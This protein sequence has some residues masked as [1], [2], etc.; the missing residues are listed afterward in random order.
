MS[1]KFDST[2]IRDYNGRLT[3]VSP[4]TGDHRTFE[5][6]TGRNGGWSAG[7]RVVWLRNETDEGHKVP[8]AFVQPNGEVRLFRKYEQHDL[9]PKY[10]RMLMHPEGYQAK[11]AEYRF[12]E[13]CRRCNAVLTHPDSLDRGLGPECAK[14]VHRAEGQASAKRAQ[15]VLAGM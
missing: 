3:I 7:K 8:F 4:A 1:L 5:I 11:G 10:A 2:T 14:I 9:Y 15:L 13:R 12:E 6:K